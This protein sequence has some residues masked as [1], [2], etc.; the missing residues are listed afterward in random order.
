MR[1]SPADQTPLGINGRSPFDE[2]ELPTRSRPSLVRRKQ[3]VK[4]SRQGHLKN[5]VEA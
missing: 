4:A 3:T 1:R 2:L 5:A